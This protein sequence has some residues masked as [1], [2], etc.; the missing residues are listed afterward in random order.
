MLGAGLSAASLLLA[1]SLARQITRP[2]GQLRQAFADASVAPVKL[3]AM[4]PPEILELQDT[5]YRATV[6]RTKSNQALLDCALQA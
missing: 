1:W 5:L 3:I 6:E 4:A 2:I